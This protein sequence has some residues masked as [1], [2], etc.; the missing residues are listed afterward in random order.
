MFSI[1]FPALLYFLCLSLTS[2]LL[3]YVLTYTL[4]SHHSVP[5]QSPVSWFRWPNHLPWKSDSLSF[6]VWLLN[7]CFYFFYLVSTLWDYVI[8]PFPFLSLSAPICP[9]LFSF[10][11]M[12][13]FINCEIMSPGNVRSYT[14]EVSPA[15]LPRHELNKGNRHAK[16]DRGKPMKSELLFSFVF[17]ALFC[18]KIW[19]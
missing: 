4:P 17:V 10:K 19:M 15:E 6:T 2:V 16:V 18:F 3:L 14:H 12:S 11:F 5:C 13:N 7:L 8:S 9:S 1:S